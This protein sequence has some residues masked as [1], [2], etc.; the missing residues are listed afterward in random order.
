MNEST[1]ATGG[2][3]R[4]REPV[5]T[6]NRGGHAASDRGFTI[7]ELL[8]IVLIIGIL[9]VIAVPA[10]VSAVENAQKKTCYANQRT[11]EGAVNIWLLDENHSTV[12]TLAGVVNAGH[13]LIA[14]NYI[15]RAPRC[16]AA[17]RPANPNNP[18]AAEGAYT[19]DATGTVVGCTFGGLGPHGSYR[20]Q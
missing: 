18:T 15:V 20:A 6:T 14:G 19:M 13:P 1:H 5:C 17:P 16:P 8:F 3:G 11:I 12:A 2:R 10:L 7:I 9:I 4:S